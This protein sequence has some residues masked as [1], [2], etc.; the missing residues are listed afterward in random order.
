MNSTN[1]KAQTLARSQ[2][3][4]FARASNG[5]RANLDL[6]LCFG[7][8]FTGVTHPKENAAPPRTPLG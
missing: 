4:V 3:E 8:C 7:G 6:Q 2:M 1:T 5:F